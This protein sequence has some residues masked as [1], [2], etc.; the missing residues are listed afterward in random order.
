[1]AEEAAKCPHMGPPPVGIHVSVVPAWSDGGEPFGLPAEDDATLPMEVLAYVFQG[2]CGLKFKNPG[3]DIWRVVMPDEGR[4]YPPSDAGW[5][6]Q[7]YVAVQCR[8]DL[9]VFRRG[10]LRKTL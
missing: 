8:A 5:G 10:M 2:A 4:L 7:V 9:L 6:S 1:M 3:T